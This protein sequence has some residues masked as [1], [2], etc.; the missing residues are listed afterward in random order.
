MRRTMLF[1]DSKQGI[2]GE[3][4]IY[5][6]HQPFQLP[7]VRALPEED[8]EDLSH[9]QHSGDRVHQELGQEDHQVRRVRRV[10]RG[11]RI[12]DHGLPGHVPGLPD[13]GQR[14]GHQSLR[15]SAALHN[16]LQPQQVRIYV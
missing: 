5:A 13:G 10:P 12:P 3:K 14:P 4:E 15:D 6:Q 8:P 7:V 11:V 1:S 9:H 2:P 16:A